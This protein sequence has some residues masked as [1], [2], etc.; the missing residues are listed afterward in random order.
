MRLGSRGFSFLRVENSVIGPWSSLLA[1]GPPLFSSPC[2]CHLKI[3]QTHPIHMHRIP[4]WHLL[5]P[6]FRLRTRRANR[7]ASQA[8]I[9]ENRQINSLPDNIVIMI[10]IKQRKILIFLSKIFIIIYLFIM[11]KLVYHHIFLSKIFMF[12][13]GLSFCMV[14]TT[15]GV[16]L[17]FWWL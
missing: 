13:F 7:L 14:V 6:F 12:L 1:L 3:E 15:N 9:I 8:V 10:V 2:C 4:A 11:G 16:I 5:G 17:T